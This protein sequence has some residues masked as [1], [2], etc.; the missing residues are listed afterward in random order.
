MWLP[1]CLF[2]ALYQ[3]AERMNSS[4]EWQMK[5]WG[6]PAAAAASCFGSDNFLTPYSSVQ[7]RTFS[8]TEG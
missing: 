4:P 2:H 1:F 7:L 3:L 5:L 6:R 8:V